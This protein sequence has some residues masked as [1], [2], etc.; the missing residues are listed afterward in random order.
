VIPLDDALFALLGADPFYT[1]RG[2]LVTER[3]NL[4]EDYRGKFLVYRDISATPDR[5]QGHTSFQNVT[6]FL[7]AGIVTRNLAD[8]AE[9]LEHAKSLLDEH[10]YALA[11]AAGRLLS[12][13]WRQRIP[14][15]PTYAASVIYQE[16]TDRYDFQYTA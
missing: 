7:Q 10:P 14:S 12:C 2:V 9:L 4:P 6:Y 11:L 3:G 13:F 1:Q 8:A 15:P 16:L 5:H